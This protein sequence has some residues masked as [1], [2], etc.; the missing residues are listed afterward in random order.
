MLLLYRLPNPYSSLDLL[1]NEQRHMS[2]DTSLLHPQLHC[3]SLT[4]SR[5]HF[6]SCGYTEPSR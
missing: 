3:P 2:C 4:D 5:A 6:P 1:L